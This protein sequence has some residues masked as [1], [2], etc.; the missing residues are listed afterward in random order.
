M[1]RTENEMD[2][3]IIVYGTGWCPA[4]VR[5]KMVLSQRGIDY[6]WINI[7]RDADG[8]TF[9]EAVNSGMRSVPTIVFPDGDILVEPSRL[10]LSE[11]LGR[12]S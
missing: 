8:R 2:G 4:C 3:E 6:K 7:D 9:V 5:V 1:T 10:E 11:K 12:F